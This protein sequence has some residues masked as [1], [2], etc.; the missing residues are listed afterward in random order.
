MVKPPPGT[1]NIAAPL[2]FDASG[3]KGITAGLSSSLIP[4]A[5]GAPPGHRRIGSA[6]FCADAEKAN[7][8]K[9]K[10]SKQVSFMI[11]E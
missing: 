2:R 4:V 8:V 5:P 9:T 6:S 10:M 3:T 7:V 11:Q 1:T